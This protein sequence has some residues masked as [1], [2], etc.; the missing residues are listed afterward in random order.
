MSVRKKPTPLCQTGFRLRKADLP[1]RQF[2][3]TQ[4]NELIL[5]L[6]VVVAETANLSSRLH[7]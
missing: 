7:R 6:V 5:W 4:F 3:K 1:I 2:S